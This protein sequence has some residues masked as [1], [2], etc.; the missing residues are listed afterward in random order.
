MGPGGGLRVSFSRGGAVRR[1]LPTRARVRTLAAMRR[2]LGLGLVAVAVAVA[3]GCQ[4]R[5]DE[6]QGPL[7]VGYFPN[8]THA[9]ALVGDKEGT[10]QAALGGRGVAFRQFNAGPAAMEALATGSLDAS[11]VGTGPALNTWDKLGHALHVVAG[12]ADGGAALVVRDAA[13]PADLRG[14]KLAS[15]QLGNSQDVALRFW[16]RQQGLAGA[17][18]V[19]SLPSPDI[20]AIFSRKSIE[21]AWVPEPWTSRLLRSGGKILVDERALWPK[22]RFPTTVLVVSADAL[23]RRPEDVRKLLVAHVELTRRWERDPQAFARAANAAF[24]EITGQ[25]LPDALVEE[26]FTR[27]SPSLRPSEA[28]LEEAA[29]RAHAVGYLKSTD[30]KGLVDTA[31]LDQVLGQGTGV[32]GAGQ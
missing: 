13:S 1:P 18:S 10:F 19:V 26:A 25:S 2:R 22:G 5:G 11:Y 8:L 24:R 28:A 29:R 21:G 3:C 6:A 7:R 16:L 30:L 12:S 15:P 14:K 31:L 9:Q 17:V 4:R 32:G 20:V 23:R 27:M